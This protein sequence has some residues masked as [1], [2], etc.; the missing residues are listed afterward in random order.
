MTAERSLRAYAQELRAALWAWRAAR[1]TRRLL[2]QRQVVEVVR[3]LPEVPQLPDGATRGVSAVLRRRRD[4][5]LVR[6][7]VLQAWETAHGRE[8]EL[9]IGVEPSTRGFSAHAWLDGDTMPAG[10]R[11][12]EIS[13]VRVP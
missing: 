2:K 1:G 7:I 10:R 6:S 13:R 4:T 12:T 3:A 5:C 8:R 9:V 11:F